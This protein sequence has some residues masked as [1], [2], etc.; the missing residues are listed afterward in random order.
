M[1]KTL[2]AIGV[3]L[4]GFPGGSCFA[5]GRAVNGYTASPAELQT[6]SSIGARPTAADHASTTTSGQTRTA[7]PK[8]YYVL[9]VLLCD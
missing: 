1:R 5:D 2:I 7:G 4:I 3:A 9:D 6:I 8:C